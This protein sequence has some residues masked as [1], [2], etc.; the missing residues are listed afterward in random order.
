[1]RL[2]SRVIKIKDIQ[3]GKKTAVREGVLYIDRSEIQQLLQQDS[4]LGKVEIE[5]AHPGEKCRILQ[6]SDVIEPRAK[7]GESGLDFPGA[8]GLQ[9]IVGTGS[10][11]VLAGTA[12][13]INDQSEISG[14]SKTAIGNII[15]M[16]G[17][18]AELSIYAKTH[19][20]VVLPYP[21]DGS[22]P[23]EYKIALK[24]AGLKAAA[25]LASAGKDIPPD[26]IEVYDLPPMAEMTR[27]SCDFPKVAYIFQM[28]STSFFPIP[29]EPVLYGDSVLKFLPT[30]IHPNE[31]LD[32]ALVNTYYGIGT[33]TYLFQNHPIIK[34]LYRRHGRDLCFVGVI[35]T[36]SRSTEPERERSATMAAKMARFLL[37]AEGV[38]LT[39]TGGGAPEIDVAETA[40]KCEEAGVKTVLVKWPLTSPEE[41]GIIFNMP[42]VDA[43]V[44][45]TNPSEMVTLPPAEMTI[46]RSVKL[47][48]GSS[49]GGEL[50]I[51]KMWISGAIDQLG[52]SNL[53]SALY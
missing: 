10:S 35:L 22:S 19:N 12:V 9:G 5:L 32:G 33:E 6:V 51:R 39:K 15:D 28:Y 53:T 52:Y 30:I 14:P 1:M 23:A 37:G 21:A 7:V 8:L 47:D 48:D 38:I 34:E 3:F 17:P 44:C 29:N 26:E 41:G 2:E 42:K 24:L 4:R 16:W 27:Q 25:Y 36:T 49:A 46:G 11:C 45:T 20:V 31:I 13:V 43:I 40:Q 18:G 50:R